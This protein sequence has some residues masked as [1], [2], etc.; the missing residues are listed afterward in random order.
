MKRLISNERPVTIDI[1]FGFSGTLVFVSVILI[2]FGRF[3]KIGTVFLLSGVFLIC[4]L[5]WYILLGKIYKVTFDRSFIFLSRFG[6]TGKIP[7]ENVL[8]VKPYVL[9]LRIQGSNVHLVKVRFMENQVK[10]K[11]YFFSRSSFHITGSIDGIP[12]LE[13]LR[14]FI[15]EKNMVPM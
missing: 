13:A 3:S 8:D 1:F 2:I 4:L 9:P 15:L 14:Q 6:K 10:R 5:F 12:N 11:V 7:L